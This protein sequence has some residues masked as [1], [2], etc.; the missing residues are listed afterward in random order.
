TLNELFKFAVF[1]T[2]LPEGSLVV[3]K[4]EKCRNSFSHQPMRKK[5]DFLIWAGAE[6]SP[7][8][9][10]IR[11]LDPFSHWLERQSPKLLLP[12][13]PPLSGTLN[14]LFCFVD[15]QT[16]PLKGFKRSFAF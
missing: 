7:E 9:F 15:F 5:C 16:P 6:K 10:L 8:P 13:I 12:Q 4:P 1:H 14:E 11:P 2:P 3:R